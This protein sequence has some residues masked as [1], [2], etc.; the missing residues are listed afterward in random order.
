MATTYPY[1]SGLRGSSRVCLDSI[2]TFRPVPAACAERRRAPERSLTE[3]FFRVDFEV[4]RHAR[5]RVANNDL[6][7]ETQ[8]SRPLS[9]GRHCAY[10]SGAS[11]YL[12]RIWDR[13]CRDVDFF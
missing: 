2:R 10:F 8:G 1:K 4:A 12:R 7:A 13:V 6:G 5:V 3:P 11:R 9:V